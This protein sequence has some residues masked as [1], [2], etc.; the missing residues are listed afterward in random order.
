MTTWT[1]YGVILAA[2]VVAAAASADVAWDYPHGWP[3]CRRIS[4]TPCGQTGDA[5][6]EVGPWVPLRGG[7]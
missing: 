2:G 6:V 3:A 7:G 1:E 4:S 5:V